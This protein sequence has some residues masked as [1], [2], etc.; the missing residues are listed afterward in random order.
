MLFLTKKG[1]E[2]HVSSA[3][4]VSSLFSLNVF[5]SQITNRPFCNVIISWN[6]LLQS[7]FIV[8]IYKLNLN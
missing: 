6:I 3:I 5:F 4:Y 2:S 1:M 7:S 8:S